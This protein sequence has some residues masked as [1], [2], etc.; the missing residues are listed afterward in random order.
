MSRLNYIFVDF[1]NVQE[2]QLDRIA[3]KPVKLSLILGERHRSLPLD[4]VKLIHKYSDQV[5]LVS[6][7]LAG[8]K[9]LDFVLACEVGSRC[10]KDPKGYFHVL[11]RDKGFDALIKHLK[12]KGVLAARHAA[13][14]EIPV[15]MNLDERVKVV[16]DHFKANQTS[17]AKTRN[18]LESQIQAFFGKALSQEEVEATVQGLVEEGVMALSKDARVTYT[19]ACH[20]TCE[21]TLVSTSGQQVMTPTIGAFHESCNL[22]KTSER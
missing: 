6:T 12:A 17:R 15:L 10:E 19:I 20:A 16:A 13:F 9:A 5:E 2:Q 14:S 18:T 11:S 8:K 4:F 7:G 21:S 3:N 22:F 1:E